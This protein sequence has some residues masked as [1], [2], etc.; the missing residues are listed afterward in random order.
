MST[1]LHG[2]TSQKTIIFTQH[3]A[4]E[5]EGK[6]CSGDEE[7]DGRIILKCALK[8]KGLGK[9]GFILSGYPTNIEGK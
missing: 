8:K 5:S 1:I 6:E 3:L 9:T 7:A 4:E 2:V